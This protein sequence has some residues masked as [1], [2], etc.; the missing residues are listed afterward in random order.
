MSEYVLK[1]PEVSLVRLMKW[2]SSWESL[3]LK[4][5]AATVWEK[6]G[7]VSRQ[8]RGGTSWAREVGTESP[9]TYLTLRHYR[10]E[11]WS[12]LLSAFA[13]LLKATIMCVMSA[14]PH[15]TTLLPLEGFSWTL[16]FEYFSENLSRKFAVSLKSDKNKEYFTWNPI[17][18]F[19]NIS[20]NSS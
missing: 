17:Y 11:T 6:V 3:S 10:D 19:N 8:R 2:M 14:P 5:T 20:L 4:M 18:I 9:C 13:K 1:C 16:I 15:G 7:S 12:G